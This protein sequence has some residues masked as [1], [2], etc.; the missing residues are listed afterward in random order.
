MTLL[1]HNFQP[2]DRQLSQFGAICIVALPMLTWLWTH[3]PNW[4]GYAGV[5]G[6]T[7]SILGLISPGLLKP[8]FVGLTLITLPIGIFAGE[9]AMLAIYFGLFLPLAIVFR[10][11]G[12]DSL[13]RKSKTSDSTFW[14]PRN[15]TQNPRNYYRQS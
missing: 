9:I 4:C 5:A 14:R 2:T 8:V 13:G 15:Q 12:R 6:L 11:I 7:L 3:N 1:N 10:L